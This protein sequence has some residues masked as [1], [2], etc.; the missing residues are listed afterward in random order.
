MIFR[1]LCNL[2]MMVL[3]PNSITTWEFLLTKIFSCIQWLGWQ[4]KIW[5]LAHLKH[6]ETKRWD[7]RMTLGKQG[8]THIWIPFPL[9]HSCNN[10]PI[11]VVAILRP[12]LETFYIIYH[13]LH[14]LIFTISSYQNSAWSIYLFFLLQT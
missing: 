4:V 11:V 14:L 2:L 10:S 7:L 6:M 8:F 9:P 3:A 13:H 12:S 5:W 1:L